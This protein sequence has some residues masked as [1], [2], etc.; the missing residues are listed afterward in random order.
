MSTCYYALFHLLCANC[1]DSLIGSAGSDRSDPA[2]LQTYRAVEHGFA[3]NRC[4]DGKIATFPEAVEDFAALFIEM[5]DRRHDA[6]YDPT[7]R[8][9]RNEVIAMIQRTEDAVTRFRAVP[10]RH[11]RAFAAF[12]VLRNR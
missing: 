3:K 1:A 2:W 6:D 8:F 9:A 5:Q 11:R 7:S 10:L 12:T 4:K